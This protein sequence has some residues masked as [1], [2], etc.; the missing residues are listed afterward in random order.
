MKSPKRA[1]YT[2]LLWLPRHGLNKGSSQLSISL[3]SWFSFGRG[4]VL[5]TVLGK[6]QRRC[7]SLWLD[8]HTFTCLGGVHIDV[9]RVFHSS[10]SKKSVSFSSP[11]SAYCLTWLILWHLYQLRLNIACTHFPCAQDIITVS[12]ASFLCFLHP[13]LSMRL[14]ASYRSFHAK[15]TACSPVSHSTLEWNNWTIPMIL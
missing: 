4:C 1:A 11:P 2:P 15:V 7:W 3:N 12:S 5:V 10:P 8:V 13:K 6:E 14:Y 9:Y